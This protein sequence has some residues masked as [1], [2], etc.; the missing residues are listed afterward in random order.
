[1][2][3]LIAAALAQ[4]ESATPTGT[5]AP[6]AAATHRT[7]AH[8]ADLA[9]NAF[10]KRFW[11]P[12]KNWF[13]KTSDGKEDLDFWM[14]AHVWQLVMDAYE[15]TG[16]DRYAAQA[17]AL[18]ATFI[19]RYGH[20][21]KKNTWNDDI[22]WWV[23]A[24]LRAHSLFGDAVFLDDA[25]SNFDWIWSTQ[26]D[27]ALGGGIYE[28]NDKHTEKNSCVNFPAVIAAAQ[29]AKAL[30]SKEYLDRAV[31]L[32][33]WGRKTLSDGKGRVWDNMALSGKVGGGSTHY[34]QGTYLGAA[35]QLFLATGEKRYLDDAVAA[36]DWTRRNL[37]TDEILRYESHKDLQGGKLILIHHL[38]TLIVDCRQEQFRPWLEKNAGAMWKNRSPDDLTWGDWTQPPTGVWSTWSA[39]SG[40]GLLQVLAPRTSAPATT[41]A[42]KQG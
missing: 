13:Y 39:A 24:N 3:V 11:N 7:A 17:R 33:A 18:H 26:R 34:N 1:M 22:V 28:N 23:L 8:D 19:K 2:G 5:P 38:E 10:N 32:F 41:R 35:A 29:L 30:K 6:S 12:A 42:P 40:V 27:D 31:T 36:A 14:S 21:W 16:E 20:D 9:M 37:C 4:G 25:R 15:R